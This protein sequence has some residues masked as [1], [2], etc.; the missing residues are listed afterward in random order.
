MNF[1][2]LALGLG[3]LTGIGQGDPDSTPEDR[4]LTLRLSPDQVWRQSVDCTAELSFADGTTRVWSFDSKL[5]LQCLG[6]DEAGRYEIAASF[7]DWRLGWADEPFALEWHEGKFRG[8]GEFPGGE[9]GSEA[10]R[11]IWKAW[12]EGLREADLRFTLSADGGIR[13]L[14]GVGALWDRVQAGLEAQPAAPEHFTLLFGPQGLGRVEAVLAFALSIPRPQG[15]VAPGAVW[16]D[17]AWLPDLVQPSGLIR[18]EF[19]LVGFEKDRRHRLARV[20]LQP[21]IAMSP[22]NTLIPRHV[23]YAPCQPGTLEILTDSGLLLRLDV[24]LAE[25]ARR[26]S[27][28]ALTATY[29]IRAALED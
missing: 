24:E 13:D 10:C 15:P 12:S 17:D 23:S 11:D 21:F 2:L 14:R 4:D 3:L 16:K 28:P 8:E 25:Q 9:E 18:R 20:E 29:H 7:I 1:S 27:L 22:E 19:A 6:L 5:R 26:A